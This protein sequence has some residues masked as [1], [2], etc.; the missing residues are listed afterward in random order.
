MKNSIL[1][2]SIV[3]MLIISSGCASKYVYT[4][5]ELEDVF[6]TQLNMNATDA[7]EYLP[8]LPSEKTAEML[9]DIPSRTSNVQAAGLLLMRKISGSEGFNIA[10]QTV[11]DTTATI[12]TVPT[13]VDTIEHINSF[14]A[15]ARQA[16]FEAVYVKVTQNEGYNSDEYFNY[17]ENHICAGIKSGDK[18]FLFDFINNPRAYKSYKI[19]S[20]PEAIVNIMNLRGVYWDRQYRLSGNS[21]FKQKAI[22]AYKGAFTL[23]PDFAL[24]MNNLAVINIRDGNLQ[25]AESLLINSLEA[26]DTMHVSRYNLAEI[27]LR[28]GDTA[29]AIELLHESLE[30][31]PKDPYTNYRLGMIY[32]VQQET[33]EA[34]ERF[35]KAISLKKNYLEPRLSLISLLIAN[36]RFNDAKAIFEDS[37]VLFP[38]SEKLKAFG[39]SL[40]NN[41]EILSE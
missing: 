4:P 14:I 1:L 23:V 38:E 29:K 18:I 10:T 35:L 26:D 39:S 11:D 34:E 13:T 7:K 19:L 6:K 8:F 20:D 27:Y 33:K 15:L 31:S 41:E 36:R 9:K 21:E 32:F 24:A 22:T 28:K 3:L 37:Q 16:G 17:V 25:E 12:A 40:A 2:I 5:Q 30:K